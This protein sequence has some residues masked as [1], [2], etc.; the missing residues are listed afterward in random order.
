MNKQ[1]F[2]F[3][4]GIFDIL[5]SEIRKKIR[6]E[7]SKSEIF[8]L[9]VYTNDFIENELMN[10]CMKT[11]EQRIEIAE[12]LDG[13]DF[14][15]P[16]DSKQSEKVK[17]EIESAYMKYL[18]SQ[19][20]EKEE[21]FKVGFV[22]G[23]FDLLHSGH[24]ENIKLAKEQCQK[25]AAVVKTDERIIKNKKKTPLQR[26]AERASILG[27]LKSIDHVFYMD[28]DTTR[29][30]LIDEIAEYYNV[31]K[32]DMVII[33]GSDLKEK[34]EAHKEELKDINVLFTDRDKKKMETVSSSYY[35]EKCKKNN[36]KLE[37]LENLEEEHLK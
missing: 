5:S 32:S 31:E 29:A 11:T 4:I 1:K 14:A 12:L 27:E 19:K 20:K 15:F 3:S 28:L 30:E 10:E 23:S 7:A 21:K 36:R 26:T 6:E 37:D 34:E 8:A 22:I 24:I 13:V 9:G 17:E 33:F 2:G 25:L 18:E 16:V 35:Q